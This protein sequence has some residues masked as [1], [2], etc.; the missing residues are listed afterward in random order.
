MGMEINKSN[1]SFLF[2]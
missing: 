1:Q 2:L